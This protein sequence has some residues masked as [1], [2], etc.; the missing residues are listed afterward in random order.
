MGLFIYAWVVHMGLFIWGCPYGAGP[1]NRNDL[2]NKDLIT[3]LIDI[4]N[5]ISNL[6]RQ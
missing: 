3:A 1:I 2:F 5:D 4:Q 6:N